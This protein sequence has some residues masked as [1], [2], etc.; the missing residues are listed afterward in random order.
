MVSGDGSLL[1]LLDGDAMFFSGCAAVFELGGG[2]VGFAVAGADFDADFAVRCGDGGVSAVEAGAVLVV[3][4]N[5]ESA[6]LAEEKVFQR[7]NLGVVGEDGEEGPE[8]ALLH[9]HGGGHDVESA[10][11]EGSFGDVGED[12]RT[13]VVDGGF[14]D[15]DG[16]VRSVGGFADV[17]CGG[18]WESLWGC[19]C[20]RRS[21]SARRAWRVEGRR[22]ERG[23]G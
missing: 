18:R 16:G 23:C 4:A 6:G 8:A 21:R 17:R 19:A 2:V 12:L 22:W 7:W 20:L 9:L 15:G 10:K 14:E 5:A 3:D 1:N 11:G 13:E